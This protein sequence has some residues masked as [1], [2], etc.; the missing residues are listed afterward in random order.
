MKHADEK[1]DSQRMQIEVPVYIGNE[2]AV[3]RE[4]SRT[5]A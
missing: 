3:A 4:I 1:R 2:K 5:G